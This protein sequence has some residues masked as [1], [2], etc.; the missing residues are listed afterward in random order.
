MDASLFFPAILLII[1]PAK[2]HWT[3]TIIFWASVIMI[4]ALFFFERRGLTPRVIIAYTLARIS[5]WIG[6]GM[7]P[8]KSNLTLMR[9]KN[10]VD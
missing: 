5:G 6:G 1:H 10:N 3:F 4:F 2:T 9:R 8:T 7:R